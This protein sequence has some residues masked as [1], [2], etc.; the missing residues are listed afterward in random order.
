[1]IKSPWG[2]KWSPS[3]RWLKNQSRLNRMNSWHCK[4]QN[5]QRLVSSSFLASCGR[6]I[7]SS[8]GFSAVLALRK[9]LPKLMPQPSFRGARTPQRFASSC[10]PPH[11]WAESPVFPPKPWSPH[12]WVADT[13]FHLRW[14]RERHFPKNLNR[15]MWAPQ[16]ELTLDFK[17]KSCW[18]LAQIPWPA[19]CQVLRDYFY[20]YLFIKINCLGAGPQ[21]DRI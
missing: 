12:H 13:V 11:C 7:C 1:M 2:L 3:Q 6:P 19:A 18:R 20:H 8:W 9:V 16:S 17:W 21:T 4:C 15:P 5:S 10:L 14:G